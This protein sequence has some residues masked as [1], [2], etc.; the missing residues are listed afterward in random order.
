[1]FNPSDIQKLNTGIELWND[2]NKA[3]VISEMD[4]LDI[5]RYSYSQN[6]VSLR[7][8]FK[9]KLRKRFDLINKISYSM[10]RSAVFLHKGVSRGHGINNPRRAK[11][12]YE[13]VV[14]RNID[15]LADVVAEGQGNLVV[16]ALKIK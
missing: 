4:A 6:P 12:W 1:M 14:D 11:E 10:P 3:D 15:S 2:K 5:K 13:P 7:K 16:N 9:S 8:A